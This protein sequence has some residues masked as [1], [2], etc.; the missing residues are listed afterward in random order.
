MHYSLIYKAAH[1]VEAASSVQP[2][3]HL[4]RAAPDLARHHHRPGVIMLGDGVFEYTDTF[5]CPERERHTHTH[6]QHSWNT[7]RHMHKNADAK[8]HAVETSRQM[9]IEQRRRG[10]VTLSQ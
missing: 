9:E 2:P 8:A 1:L 3:T 4:A 7:S 6:S 10:V 5:E